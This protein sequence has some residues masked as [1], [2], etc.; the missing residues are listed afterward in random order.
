MEDKLKYKIR[1]SVAKLG[2]IQSLDMFGDDMVYQA[3]IDNPIS[4]L[5]QFKNLKPIKKDGEIRYVD[6]HNLPLFYY[7]KEELES[8]YGIYWISYTRIWLFF[9]EFFGYKFIEIQKIMM[10]WLET[11]YNLKGL[12]PRTALFQS[13]EWLS[14][15]YNLRGLVPIKVF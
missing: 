10:E 4:F 9:E 2:L 12:T 11:T 14:S 3:F 5:N 13:H 1:V 7:K 8:K 6:N 15:P